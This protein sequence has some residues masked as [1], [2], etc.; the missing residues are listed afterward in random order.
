MS[1]SL[2]HIRVQVE[3]RTVC[4]PRYG[5]EFRLRYEDPTLR[6]QE[7]C[8][9]SSLFNVPPLKV[10]NVMSEDDKSASITLCL[11]QT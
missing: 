10:Q 5:S 11:V 3:S 1:D 7:P 6:I 9:Q 2:S 4:A 8:R